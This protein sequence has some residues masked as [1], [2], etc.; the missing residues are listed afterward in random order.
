RAIGPGVERLRHAAA[1]GAAEKRRPLRIAI[2]EVLGDLPRVAH[3]RL[4]IL[5]DRHRLAAGEGDRGLVAHQHGLTVVIQTLVLERHLRAPREHAVAAPVPALQF[6]ERH[7]AAF[8]TPTSLLR[9]SPAGL[10]DAA[11]SIPR[12]RARRCATP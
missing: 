9:G 1:D 2:L 6:P 5:D 11:P 8:F 3:H 4:A 7:H 12:A 10:S